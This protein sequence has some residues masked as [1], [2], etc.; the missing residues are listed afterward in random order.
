MVV[1]VRILGT[2]HE[3]QGRWKENTNSYRAI[4]V[5]LLPF[6]KPITDIHH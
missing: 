1:A 5:F 4:M 2:R 6:S 3:A